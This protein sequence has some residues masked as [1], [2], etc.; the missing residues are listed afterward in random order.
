MA[1]QDSTLSQEY[2]HS[3]FEYRDGELYSKVRRSN[4]KI[5]SKAGAQHYTGYIFTSINAKHYAVHRIIFCMHYGFFPKAIDHINGIKNDNRIENL[6]EATI[7]ENNRN[8]KIRADNNS[9]SKGVHFA[10]QVNKW[11][12]QMQINNK[13]MYFGCF[14]DLE[15]AD[16][17][18][19][20]ARAKY[21]GKFARHL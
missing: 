3:I 11:L 17:V 10:K 7:A 21:H 14:D 6:R 1:T 12:V 16:L 20:E 4:M 13:K 18:A 19:Q 8:A 15:L 9:G 2:L 5:G